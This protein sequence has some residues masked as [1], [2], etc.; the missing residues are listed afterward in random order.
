MSGDSRRWPSAFGPLVSEKQL[1]RVTRYLEL[2]R[3]EGAAGGAANAVRMLSTS[4]CIP[5]PFG[6]ARTELAELGVSF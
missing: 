5:R 1:N 6:S 3:K 2:G 4:T